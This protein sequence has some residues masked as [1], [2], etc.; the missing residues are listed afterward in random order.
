MIESDPIAYETIEVK[1]R[2]KVGGQVVYDFIK[3]NTEGSKKVLFIIPGVT[4]NIN[5]HHIKATCRKAHKE[6]YNIIVV[7]PVAPPDYSGDSLEVIEYQTDRAISEH[8]EDIRSIFGQESEI[9]A[10]GFS[11]GSNHLLRH[12][13]SH[14]DCKN[15]CGIKAAASISG[16]FE[17]PANT[18]TL[19]NRVFGIYDWYMVGRLKDIFA[20]QQFKIQS[21]SQTE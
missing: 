1:S 8:V 6:G 16:A 21:T 15:V 18:I 3:S 20:R 14:E 11:L 5:E 10:L 17:L 4:C 9:Y 19:R 12:L 2:S 13:G 7:N